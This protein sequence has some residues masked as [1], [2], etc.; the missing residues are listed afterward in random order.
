MYGGTVLMEGTPEEIVANKEVRKV[1]LGENFDVAWETVSMAITPREIKQ[2]S[3][4]YDPSIATG[5]KP[6]ANE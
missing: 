6:F 3:H 4:Y 2:L 5:D 1:Y